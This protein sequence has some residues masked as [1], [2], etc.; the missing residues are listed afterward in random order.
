MIFLEETLSWS[1]FPSLTPIISPSFIDISTY[2]QGSSCLQSQKYQA[3]LS[4]NVQNCI[5]ARTSATWFYW[6][7]KFTATATSQVITNI[8][9]NQRKYSNFRNF[10]H[11]LKQCG[12][13]KNCSHWKI[14]RE[15]DSDRIDNDFT[16]FFGENS[17][18]DT[19]WKLRKFALTF[20]Q[21]FRENN[22][23]LR[24]Y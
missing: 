23:F 9:R 12:I 16:Q 22:V 14:F 15:I 13:P 19:V 20:W 5:F 2:L 8:W 4:N 3:L 6:K 21:K 1:L 24:N 7:W 10:S 17:L 11:F 18:H